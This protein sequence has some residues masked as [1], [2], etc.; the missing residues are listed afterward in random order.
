MCFFKFKPILKTTLWGGEKLI[1]LKHLTTDNRQIG[2]SWEI[3]G[4]EDNVSIVADGRWA[5]MTL[6]ELIDDRKEKL[7]GSDNY[8]LFG[9]E[10]PLLFKWIDARLD[11]S[12]Q[13]HPDDANAVRRGFKRGKTEM[14]YLLESDAEA[15]LYCGLKQPL[16]PERYTRMV[17][18][19]SICNALASY[20]VHEGDVFFLPPGRIHAIGAGCLLAEI[21]QTSDVTYRIYDFK[22]RDS[23]GNYRQ[24]H[25]EEAAE[26]I[27]Y[28]VL[29]DYR[30][31][32]IPERNTGVQLVTCP[33][34]NTAVYD[35]D[36][37]MTLDYSE[38]DAFVVLMCVKGEGELADNEGEKTSISIG[39][40]ILIPASTHEV[41]VTG[42]LK[43]LET[44][45]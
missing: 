25:T 43:F 21:Q 26:C 27:D 1:S 16:T 41:T 3:S 45:L 9:N 29:P 40:T 23:Q 22:R 15:Q 39:D 44:Y 4:V 20:R 5:G 6:K 10:F 28:R 7:M 19:G 36:E 31:S 37:P 32:Y 12:I 2:E 8:K 13:V 17:E 24:L 34:F 30:T 33:H 35:I 38:L 42:K 18:D 14:W 11:L